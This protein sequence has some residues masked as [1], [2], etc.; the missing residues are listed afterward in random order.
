MGIPLEE[1]QLVR[2]LRIKK[3]VAMNKNGSNQ[4]HKILVILSSVRDGRHGAKVAQAVMK[5]LGSYSNLQAEIL[6]PM[7]LDVPMLKQPLHFMPDQ[8]VAPS[9]M[10]NTMAMLKEANGFVIVSA[11]YNCTIPPALTNLLDHFP[12]SA[13]RHKPA[14]IITYSMGPFGGVWATVALRP[15][16][17]ELGM[18]ILPSTVAIPTIQNSGI[19][20]EG[21]TEEN[22]RVD[23]NMKKLCGELAWYVQ[24]LET[25]KTSSDGVPN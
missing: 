11:E 17:S 3:T 15:F 16:L 24:A 14:S 23:K 7:K 9:W 19:T 20:E 21:S 10:T 25:Q 8:S 13:Y 4:P 5:H 1:N 22:E 2:S 12:L 18:V 6:D